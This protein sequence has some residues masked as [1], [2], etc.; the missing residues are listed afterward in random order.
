MASVF[1]LTG[2]QARGRLYAGTGP[3][4]TT[5]GNGTVP[6]AF[7]AKVT[8]QPAPKTLTVTL[9]GN[10]GDPLTGRLYVTFPMTK[11]ALPAGIPGPM[12]SAWDT[13]FGQGSY[14]AN[15]LG[16]GQDG[17]GVVKNGAQSMRMEVHYTDPGPL[18][19]VAE[20]DQG[21]IYKVAF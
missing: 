11:K 18:P 4:A 15:V 8:A 20:D 12:Q 2:C 14:T 1:A 10:G 5:G 19:G 9:L 17:R 21:N 3:L 7:T 6:S 13:V 16:Q